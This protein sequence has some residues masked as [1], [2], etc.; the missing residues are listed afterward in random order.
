MLI[1]ERAGVDRRQQ[2]PRLLLQPPLILARQHHHDAVGATGS[3]GAARPGGAAILLHDHVRIRAAGAEGGDPGRCADTPARSI[4]AQHRARPGA[5]S[6]CTDERRAAQN[7][8]AGSA[9]REC[10]DG[11]SCP[12]LHLQQHLGQPG[13]S[14]RALAVA[15]VRLDRADGAELRAPAVCSPERLAQPGDLDRIAQRGAGAVR[16]DVARSP[17]GS[18]PASCSACAITCACACGLGTV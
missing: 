2:P 3:R 16:F 8:C 14:G 4:Q 17:R 1:A 6:R 5:S 10:S 12:C 11:T 9:P 18:I 15:D 13:D 7:R